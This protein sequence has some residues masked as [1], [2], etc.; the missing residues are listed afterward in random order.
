MTRI[1]GVTAPIY[2]HDC[3]GCVFV[4]AY[5]TDIQKYDGYFCKDCDSGSVVL[6]YGNDGP[7]YASAPK[8]IY[9]MATFK[10]AEMYRM[11]D[12]DYRRMIEHLTSVTP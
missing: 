3:E 5:Q 11:V 12:A 7:Q 8:F 2:A 10:S 1:E 4:G 6:R 9:E